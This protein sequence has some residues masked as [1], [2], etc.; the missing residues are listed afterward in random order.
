MR[1]TSSIAFT[2][3]AVVASIFAATPADATCKRFGITVNDYGKEGP[4]NDAKNRSTD[5]ALN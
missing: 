3:A 5:S 1:A 2:I 4:T